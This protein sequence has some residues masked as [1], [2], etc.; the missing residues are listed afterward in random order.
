M[1]ACLDV[2]DA[3]ANVC[4]S[5]PQSFKVMSDPDHIVRSLDVSGVSQDDLYGFV[6]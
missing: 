1:L 3:F 4:G 6:I 2:D 5:V